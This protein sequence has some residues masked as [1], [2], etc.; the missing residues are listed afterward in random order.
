MNKHFSQC[1]CCVLLLDS[2]KLL[3]KCPGCTNKPELKNQIKF[4]WYQ[5]HILIIRDNPEIRTWIE[6]I[7]LAGYIGMV[8]LCWLEFSKITLNLPNPIKTI[9]AI[10]FTGW[11]GL[12]FGYLDAHQKL[13][14]NPEFFLTP[15]FND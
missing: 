1:Q 13:K 7:I 6:L 8:F 9:I 2:T 5:K 3:V 4:P 15:N 11:F 12:V 14:T 10:I